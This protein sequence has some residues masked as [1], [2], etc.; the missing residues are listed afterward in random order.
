MLS[1]KQAGWT[2]RLFPNPRQTIVNDPI[3]MKALWEAVSGLVPAPK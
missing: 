1:A 2:D 3:S